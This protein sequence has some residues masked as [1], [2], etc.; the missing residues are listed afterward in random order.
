MPRKRKWRRRFLIEDFGEIVSFCLA[1][2]SSSYKYM[3]ICLF[4]AFAGAEEGGDSMVSK[5]R[6]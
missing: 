6:I 1:V 5:E 4:S 3:R 2:E